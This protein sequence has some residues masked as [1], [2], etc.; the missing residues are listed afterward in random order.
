MIVAIGFP[1]GEIL[2]GVFAMF[3]HDFRYLLRALYGPG[4]FFIIYL[5]LV[6]ESIQWL[7]V[8]GRVERAIKILQRTASMNGKVLSQKS[9]EMIKL[10]YSIDSKGVEAAAAVASEKTQQEQQKRHSITT[11]NTTNEN[12]N[13]YSNTTKVNPNVNEKSTVNPSIIQSLSTIFKSKTLCVRFLICCYFFVSSSFCY[14]G[15][16]FSALKIPGI[17][18]YISFILV[19]AFEIPGIVIAVPLLKFMKRRHLMFASL[20]V[21][22]LLTIVT[23]LL[24]QYNSVV[25]LISLML[26]KTSISFTYNMVYIY[27]AEQVRKIK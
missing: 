2:L 25:V 11:T 3:I 8:R 21:T 19:V 22:S 10:K 1:I 20:F 13:G 14:Y 17:S 5:W 27:V 12:G 23:P 18:G 16:N 4:I 26:A 9:I 15:M 7:L 6:P 24:P